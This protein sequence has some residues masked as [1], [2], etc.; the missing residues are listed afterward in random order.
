[1]KTYQIEYTDGEMREIPA[2]GV[3]QAQSCLIF[4]Q[5]S[6]VKDTQGKATVTIVAACDTANPNIR[7]V[8][9][10]TPIPVEQPYDA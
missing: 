1:M 6:P 10:L 7:L 9:L 5:V 8:T 3:Q 2:D 4:F